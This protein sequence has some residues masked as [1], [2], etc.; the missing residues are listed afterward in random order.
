[1]V[2]LLGDRDFLA[3]YLCVLWQ[4]SVMFRVR[5]WNKSEKLKQRDMG[6]QLERGEEEV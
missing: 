6:M 2:S 4:A 5:K 3:A 1:M